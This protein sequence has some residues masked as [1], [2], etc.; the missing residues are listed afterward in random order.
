M[1]VGTAVLAIG[2]LI[3]LV[4]PFNTRASAEAQAG[5]EAA[6]RDVAQRGGRG[7]GR[8]GLSVA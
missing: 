2:A 1:W 8:G 5:V 3:P 7:D 4:L 6:E